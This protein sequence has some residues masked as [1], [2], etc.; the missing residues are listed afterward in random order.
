MYNMYIVYVFRPALSHLFSY[1]K[2][3]NFKCGKYGDG[4]LK[5]GIQMSPKYVNKIY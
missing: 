1:E 5:V 3:C 4:Q 2:N